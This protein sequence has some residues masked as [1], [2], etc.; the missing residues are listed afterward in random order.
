MD[1]EN[2]IETIGIVDIFVSFIHNIRTYVVTKTH[3]NIYKLT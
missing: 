3:S 1:A 2:A